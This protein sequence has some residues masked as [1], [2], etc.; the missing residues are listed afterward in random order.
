MAVST[1]E[2][3]CPTCGLE[4]A[5]IAPAVPLGERLHHPVDLLGLSRQPEAP[6]ELPEW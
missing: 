5:V 4:H 6:Q 1:G 3:D 2:R